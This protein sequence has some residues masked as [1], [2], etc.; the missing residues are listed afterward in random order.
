VNAWLLRIVPDLRRA[1]VR[2]D[3]ADVVCLHKRLMSLAPDGIGPDA[4]SLAGLL[5]RVDHARSGVRILVQ[6]RLEPHTDRLP[7]GYGG[8]ESRKLGP[9]LDGLR[10]GLPVHYR[11]T[12]NPVKRGGR[13]AGPKEGKI[14]P[15][16][17]EAADAWWAGRADRCGLALR[18][19]TGMP[20]DDVTGRRAGGQV[21]HALTRYDGIAVVTDPDAARRAVLDG[22]G[23]AKSYGAGL[24]S[25]A[26]M[27]GA[28]E[29]GG[30]V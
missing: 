7:P 19:A 14:I 8:C 10:P 17:G 15:L 22:V 26:P 21:R 24:L 5:F 13:G 18:T 20:F 3:L 1:D 2:R 9:L 11:L 6:T 16:R 25:L 12:A 4:R 27:H 23:R 29:G 28:G 30:A